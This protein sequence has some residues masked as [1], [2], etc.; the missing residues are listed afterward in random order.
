MTS[1][2]SLFKK[3]VVVKYITICYHR[4]SFSIQMGER[5]PI[6]I[7]IDKKCHPE[8]YFDKDGELRIKKRFFHLY[9]KS[10]PID[11]LFNQ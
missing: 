7:R 5:E 6:V 9:T 10:L 1:L 4:Y 3:Q 2:F 11:V 8:K